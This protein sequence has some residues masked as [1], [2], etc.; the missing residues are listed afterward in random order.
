M[1]TQETGIDLQYDRPGGFGLCISEEEVA[2]R[3]EKLQYLA[4]APGTNFTYEMLDRD[5]VKEAFPMIGDAVI[6]ASYSPYDGHVN[7]LRLFR[8]LHAAFHQFGGRYEPNH[9]VG[10]IR[11]EG[12]MFFVAAG[13]QR[14][15]A[16]RLILAA[17]NGTRDLARM[18]GIDA[19]VGPQRGQVMVTAKVKPFLHHPLSLIRQT[20][21]GGVMI[22]DSKEDTGFDDGTTPQVMKALAERA[23]LTFPVLRDV[24]I[25]RTWA[26]LRVMSDDGFPVYQES[27]TCPGAFVTCVHSGVTLAAAHAGPLADAIAGG[28]LT[29]ES[30]NFGTERFHV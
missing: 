7:S 23:A 3:R 15:E 21:E 6:G 8:A 17:G 27:E 11:H 16:P 9:P 10:G 25:V 14:F 5:A 4:D 26:G 18:V 29:G 2:D 28:G 24:P 30:A 13:P 19:P 1:L 22:G 20:G 12:G